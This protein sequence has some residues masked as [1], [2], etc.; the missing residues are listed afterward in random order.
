MDSRDELISLR[1]FREI[2]ADRGLHRWTIREVETGKN[3]LH[4]H[5]LVAPRSYADG[6]YDRVIEEMVSFLFCMKKSHGSR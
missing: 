4:H 6:E 5:R 2:A 3:G 1:A